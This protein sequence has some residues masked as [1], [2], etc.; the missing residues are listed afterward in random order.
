MFY[1]NIWKLWTAKGYEL[2]RKK[3]LLA[4]HIDG[5]KQKDLVWKLSTPERSKRKN[6]RKRLTVKLR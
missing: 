1:F 5:N 3:T 4:Y 2:S 6:V